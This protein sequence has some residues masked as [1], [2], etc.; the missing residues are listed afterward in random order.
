MKTLATTVPLLAITATALAAQDTVTVKPG[1]RVRIVSERHEVLA[2]GK[3]VR[4]DGDSVALTDRR[5]SATY[6]IGGARCLETVVGRRSRAG[7]AAAGGFLFGAV[8]GGVLGAAAPSDPSGWFSGSRLE[9]VAGGAGVLGFTGMLISAF[10]G[11]LGGS[12]PVW[13]PVTRTGPA[14]VVA[15]VPGGSSRIGVSLAF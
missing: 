9:T 12:E 15:P 10:F 8:I 14:V 11:A 4:S 3:L 6:A 5:R 7:S 2:E 1:D 13:A